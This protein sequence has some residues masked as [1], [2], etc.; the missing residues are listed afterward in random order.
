MTSSL[1]HFAKM[2]LSEL[3]SCALVPGWRCCMQA[4]RRTDAESGNPSVGRSVWLTVPSSATSISMHMEGV[5]GDRAYKPLHTCLVISELDGGG[6]ARMSVTRA[7]GSS[8]KVLV[9]MCCSLLA[10]CWL[11]EKKGVQTYRGL[12]SG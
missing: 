10:G 6:R 11:E 9:I 4:R 7:R 1:L 8:I 5:M 2:L 12:G 3:L